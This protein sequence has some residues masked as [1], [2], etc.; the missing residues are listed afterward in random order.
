M[1]ASDGFT[2]EIVNDLS[3][4]ARATSRLQRFGQLHRLPEPLVSRFAVAIDELVS[5]IIRHGL[6]TECRETIRLSVAL[7]PDRFGMEVSDPGPAFDPLCEAPAPDLEAPLERRRVGGL[8]LH[9]V[10]AL[11]DSVTY[12]REGGRNIVTLSTMLR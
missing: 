10:L 4:I 3:E 5:N 1:E 6:S 12:R 2:V 7:D 9:I 11:I 8:G